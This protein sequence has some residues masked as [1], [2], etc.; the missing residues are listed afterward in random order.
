[1]KN[2]CFPHKPLPIGGPSSFQLRLTSRLLNDGFKVFYAEEKYSEKISTIV[3]V[4]GTKKIFW[5]LK[6][7][8][9]GVR[10]IHRLDGI[11]DYAFHFKDGFIKYIKSKIIHFVVNFIRKKLANHV[12]YQSQYV[13][14]VWKQY[15]GLDVSHSVIYNAV[16]L[17]EFSP[18]DKINKSSEFKI[19][20]VEG[21]VQ[22]ELAIHSLKAISLFEVNV[23]GKIHHNVKKSLSDQKYN[24]VIFHGSIPREKIHSVFTGKKIYL[25]LEINPACP[26]SVIEA[27][28]AGVPILGFDSGSLKELVGDAGK[29]L[30]YDKNVAEIL[31][32]PNCENLEVAIKEIS[33]H[34]EKYSKLARNRAEKL[35][36]INDQFERYRKIL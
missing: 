15:G 28:A 27:L 34:Y 16:D 10:I 13:K 14:N 4:G 7:K 36:D 31:E 21:T 26:N 8:I 32:A 12:V 29:I 3:V 30:P 25:C 19:V 18:I 9:S 22:G 33:Q 11:N 17:K 2:I 23:Y 5:L 20:S 6:N 1:M 35:F 24:N